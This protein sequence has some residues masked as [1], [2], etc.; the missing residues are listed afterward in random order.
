M[1]GASSVAQAM[2]CGTSAIGN[3]LANT[4]EIV[5]VPT[6]LRVPGAVY[7][8][9]ADCS[10]KA[11]NG[12]AGSNTSDPPSVCTTSTA[13][14]PITTC[15]TQLS[16]GRI[17]PPWVG[18]EG[19]QGFPGQNNFLEFGKEP[20]AAG[21]NGGIMVLDGPT[22]AATEGWDWIPGVR[23]RNS[24]IWQDVTLSASGAV[25]VGDVQVITTLPQHD[26]SEADVEIAVPL[27]S[28]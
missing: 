19:W 28:Q 23:D 26:G 1:T 13:T 18:V 6:N 9:G 4:A 12:V 24:G 15:S 3:F 21:E 2:P 25:R 14:P 20:Y 16:S 17:D 10:G 7:C 11:I 22:F 8:A 5:S 27:T